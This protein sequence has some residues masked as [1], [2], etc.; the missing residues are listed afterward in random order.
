MMDV[1][2]QSELADDERTPCEVWTRVMGYHRPVS[3]FNTGKQ[4]EHEERRPFREPKGGQGEMAR[5]AASLPLVLLLVTAAALLAGCAAP[6]VQRIAVPVPCRVALPARPLMP[7]EG[8]PP[9]VPLDDFIAAAIA[10]LERRE[11]YEIQLR[12]A[13]DACADAAP[14]PSH[15]VSEGEHFAEGSR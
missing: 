11:G 7:T 2:H 15:D 9:D 5:H 1:T 8:L 13:L 12:A 10:E 3:S 14:S 6:D 4:G